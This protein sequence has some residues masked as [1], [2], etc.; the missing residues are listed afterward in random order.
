MTALVGIVCDGG[1]GTRQWLAT[2]VQVST[3][4]IRRRLKDE[5]W[6]KTYRDGFA[7]DVCPVC[8][9]EGVR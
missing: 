5:G 6:H 7:R 9:A 2:A 4:D 8:W 3:I 1:C